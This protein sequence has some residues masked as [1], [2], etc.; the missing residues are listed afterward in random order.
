VHISGLG[1]GKRINHPREVLEENQ[2]IEV[3][4]SRVDEKQ[5][6][7]SLALVSDDQDSEA[8]DYYKKHMAASSEKSSG[9]LGTLGDILRKKLEEKKDVR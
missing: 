1:K 8:V 9:S 7:L 5:K 2:A 3:K 6:R 4:I